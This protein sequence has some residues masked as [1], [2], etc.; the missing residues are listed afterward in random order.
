MYP[1]AGVEAEVSR[2]QFLLPDG[3]SFQLPTG[4]FLLPDGSLFLE[5]KGVPPTARVPI[6]EETLLTSDDVELRTA[7]DVV[8]AVGA[9]SMPIEGGPVLLSPDAA[10]S[11]LNAGAKFLEDVAKDPGQRSVCR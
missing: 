7:E 4:R 2:G 8:L 9:G 3:L 6:N 5:G 11:A 1:T 10:G